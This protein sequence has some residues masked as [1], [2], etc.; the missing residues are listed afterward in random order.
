MEMRLDAKE[1]GAG[2][3]GRRISTRKGLVFT[4]SECRPTRAPLDRDARERASHLV[5]PAVILWLCLLCPLACTCLAQRR[6]Q[7]HN[8]PSS[9]APHSGS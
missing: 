3:V 7:S 1:R 6:G 8:L 9:G 4:L 5:L 2:R